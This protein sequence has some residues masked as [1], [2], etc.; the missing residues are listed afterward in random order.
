MAA[1]RM[2]ADGG[3]FLFRQT[4]GLVEDGE[5]NERGL[6]A[7]HYVLSEAV[8]GNGSRHS[9]EGRFAPRA[10]RRLIGLNWSA[11]P[12]F[13]LWIGGQTRSE[14]L[15]KAANFRRQQRPVWI[16]GVDH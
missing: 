13:L 14:K 4:V 7:L 11:I 1:A 9:E 16:D 15:N 8:F 10:S 3:E 2:R 6:S 5:R 12:L